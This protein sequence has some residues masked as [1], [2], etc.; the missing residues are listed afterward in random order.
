[1][2]TEQ[3]RTTETQLLLNFNRADAQI[4]TK[5]PQENRVGRCGRAC[6]NCACRGLC[7]HAR[8]N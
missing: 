8:H 1:M 5:E 2:K 4:Q 3:A 6:A 7:G